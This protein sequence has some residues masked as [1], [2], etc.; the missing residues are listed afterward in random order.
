M[1]HVFPSSSVF[2]LCQYISRQ[3]QFVAFGLGLVEADLAVTFYDA[4]GPVCLHCRWVAIMS[5]GAPDDLLGTDKP[6]RSGM[7]SMAEP[8]DLLAVL[9]VLWLPYISCIF[10]RGG[11]NPKSNMFTASPAAPSSSGFVY[12]FDRGIPIIFFVFSSGRAGTANS[13]TACV[14]TSE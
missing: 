2:L 12:A 5:D 6:C 11:D 13:I 4:D 7:S 8:G 1:A 9:S 10:W 3:C 14:Q